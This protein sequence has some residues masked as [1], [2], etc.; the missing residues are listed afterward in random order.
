EEEA[1]IVSTD[2]N[3]NPSYG[4]LSNHGTSVVATTSSPRNRLFASSIETS[5][6]CP[7]RLYFHTFSI[8]SSTGIGFLNN[9]ISSP[10]FFYIIIILYHIKIASTIFYISEKG[11]VYI[12]R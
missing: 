2:L 11:N 9:D 4:D 5:S 3:A 12:A 1:S 6:T 7:S 8:T 10:L